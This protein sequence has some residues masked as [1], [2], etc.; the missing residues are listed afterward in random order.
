M[1][2]RNVSR[3]QAI[4]LH[5][6]KVMG[7]AVERANGGHLIA[8]EYHGAGWR[9]WNPRHDRAQCMEVI[10]WA[11]VNGVSLDIRSVYVLVIT[12]YIVKHLVDHNNTP[13]GVRDAAL[14]AIARATG[15]NGVEGE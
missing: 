12:N 11:A 9:V 13:E 14:E 3:Q 6:A 8:E 1:T 7:Q 10:E 2:E 4:A 5:L 15:W